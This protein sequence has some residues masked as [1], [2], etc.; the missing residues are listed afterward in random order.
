MSPLILDH[1]I[2]ALV[3]IIVPAYAVYEFNVIKRLAEA[4]TP[5]PRMTIYRRTMIQ[6]WITAAI[7]FALWLFAKRPV[8]DI[9][10]G[11][12]TGTGA[13]IGYGITA[14]IVLALVAQTIGILRNPEKMDGLWKQVESLKDLLPSN[15]REG[16]GF[17]AVSF[18]AGVC[19]ELVYRGYMMAY[20]AAL[21]GT[22]QSVVV[23]S[24]AFGFAHAYQGP[25]GIVKTG[26]VG[27]A[28]AGLYLLTGALWAPMLL[29]FIIDANSGFLSRRVL[30]ARPVATEADAPA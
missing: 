30:E 19:E 4:G 26:V 10:F 3:I 16:N 23:S 14:A 22:W 9:G 2:T 5:M 29:H 7:V 11:F 27:A 18:T 8:A 6:Q 24:L 17:T 20:F 1:I 15:A 25:R 12:E 21:L 28:M 13:L